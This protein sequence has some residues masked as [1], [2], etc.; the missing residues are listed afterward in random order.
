MDPTNN[1]DTDT[2]PSDN[3]YLLDP[4]E[5]AE[6]VPDDPDH[7]MDSDGEDVQADGEAHEEIQLQNDS[8]AYFDLHTD[9]IF[10]IANHPLT[11]TTIATGG[12]DDT[13]YIFSA[14]VSL[15]VLPSSY[16][17]SPS[18][19]RSSLQPMAKLSGHT[20]SVNTLT[21]TLPSGEY[22]ITGGLDG[23]IRVHSTTI[24]SPTPY[25]LLASAQE[26]PEVNFLIPCPHPSHPDTFALGASDGSVWVYT[27]D[28]SDTSSPLQVLQAYYLHTGSCTAGA[29]TPDGKFLATV[30]EDGS[31]YVWDPFGEAAAAGVTDSS[32]SSSSGQAAIV[33]LTTADQRFAVEDGLF[34][35]AIAPSGAFAAVG[36]AHGIIRI[37]GLPRLSPIS[38]SASAAASKSLKAS[39]G[40][41]GIAKK[42]PGGGKKA[43]GLIETTPGGSSSS[44]QAGAILASLQVQS[45]SI[46]TL[47]FSPHHSLLAAGSVDG[48]ICLFD[49]AHRFTVRRHIKEAH[50]DGFAVVQVAFGA[51]SA[52]EAWLLTSCG[53]DGAEL[54]ASI[55]GAWQK[56]GE[57]IGAKGK[58]VGSWDL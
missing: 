37:V 6:I 38:T 3:E 24:T 44:G 39:S 16:E 20:D 53:M 58:A 26:V 56:S 28:A 22:L 23:Q 11:P 12:G 35:V 31:L 8:I 17:S 25:P 5:A 10:C 42:T 14:D 27:L 32:S 29:W 46:E 2:A 36:G 4:S 45:E 41:G 48:S 34:S 52:E 51:S 40:G 50:E 19:S 49:T 33:G 7:P 1:R 13:T 18:T 43:S 55:S 57:G 21:Y 54:R 9:S 15:P 30:S 47:A